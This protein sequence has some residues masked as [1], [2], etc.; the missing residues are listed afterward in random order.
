MHFHITF[1][2][3]LT[4]WRP[5]I[6]IP[7]QSP[8]IGAIF[9]KNQSSSVPV[10]SK[11]GQP[12]Y[13]RKTWSA[14]EVQI[15]QSVIA[16]GAALKDTVKSCA[17]LLPGRTK[18]AITIKCIRI[19][20]PYQ[21]ADKHGDAQRVRDLAAKGLTRTEIREL[22]PNRSRQYIDTAIKRH[23]V[24][25]AIKA[26]VRV[27]WTPAENAIVCEGIAHNKR[28]SELAAEL[29]QRTI[30]SIKDRFQRAKQAGGQI[31]KL[32]GKPWTDEDDVEL[33]NMYKAG[34]LYRTIAGRLQRSTSAVDRRLG[35]LKRK[36]QEDKNKFDVDSKTSGSK[37]VT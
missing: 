29:P 26:P 6:N 32:P 18:A 19:H 9:G 12:G 14:D 23:K 30:V 37:T 22:L 17:H 35:R 34:E 2:R 33:M 36:E 25:V 20:D 8:G 28:A 13:R 16:T 5:I 11:L 21:K 24:V 4:R 31:L 15:L 27:P 1:P 7:R 3:L 10:E